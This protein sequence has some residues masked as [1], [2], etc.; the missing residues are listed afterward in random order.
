MLPQVL[1]TEYFFDKQGI[2]ANHIM[3]Q[4]NT[5]AQKLETN[6][7]ISSGKQTK[8]MDVR[9]FFIKDRV[10]EGGFTIE[11]CPTRQMRGDY[12]T[13]SLQGKMF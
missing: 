9:Y 13:K 3:Y 1:W 10:D 5:S 7:K 6:R 12:F 4:D 2:T 8:H 11:H